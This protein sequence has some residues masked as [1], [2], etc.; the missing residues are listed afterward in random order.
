MSSVK[1]DALIREFPEEAQ[2]LERLVHFLDQYQEQEGRREFPLERLFEI[3]EPSSERVL[4]KILQRV[5]KQ[6]ALTRLVRIENANGQGLATFPTVDDV[7]DQIYDFTL[8][9]TIEVDHDL[10]RIIYQ[11]RSN[12]HAA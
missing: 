6:G 4:L 10:L 7:P 12:I 9:R 2:A 5:C 3:A 11:T 8:G 1:L